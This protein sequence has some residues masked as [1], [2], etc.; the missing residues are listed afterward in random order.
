MDEALANVMMVKALNKHHV[1]KMKLLVEIYKRRAFG[2]NRLSKKLTL[3]PA[4]IEMIINI[5]M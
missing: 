5:V 2:L 3:D 4:V 1:R